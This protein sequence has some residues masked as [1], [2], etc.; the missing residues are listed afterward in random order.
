M[1]DHDERNLH[2]FKGERHGDARPVDFVAND[3]RPATPR[4]RTPNS[5]TE[6]VS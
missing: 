4:S 5:S 1:G 2:Y 3:R 6:P